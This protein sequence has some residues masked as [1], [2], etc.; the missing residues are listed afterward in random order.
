MGWSQ[1]HTHA[2]THIQT[3]GTNKFATVCEPVSDLPTESPGQFRP[4]KHFRLGNCPIRLWY[5][6][7]VSAATHNVCKLL[8]EFSNHRLCTELKNFKS[9]QNCDRRVRDEFKS[10]C[11]ISVQCA[12]SATVG[13]NVIIVDWCCV[14]ACA[15]G[16]AA[17]GAGQLWRFP[18]ASS[19]PQPLI[20]S[21]ARTL[22][23][24]CGRHGCVVNMRARAAE[25]FDHP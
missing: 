2:H 21:N 16:K 14:V 10:N 5:S 24:Q 23:I 22:S 20:I 19:D 8:N 1:T 4:I 11:E 9:L 17:S 25:G 6:N 3:I 13:P 15:P 7:S 12:G 18:P